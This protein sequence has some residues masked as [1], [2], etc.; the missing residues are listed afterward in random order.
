MHGQFTYPQ[1][2]YG[3]PTPRDYRHDYN[4]PV[5]KRQ[6]SAGPYD[7]PAA[8]D[9][10]SF[11]QGQQPASVYA[12]HNMSQSSSYAQVGTSNP[13]S[14]DSFAFRSHPSMPGSQIPDYSSSQLSNPYDPHNRYAQDAQYGDQAAAQRVAQSVAVNRNTSPADH[15]QY[16]EM[17]RYG[18]VTNSDQRDQKYQYPAP[19]QSTYSTTENG[20]VLPPLS[21]SGAAAQ[22][23]V[24]SASPYTYNTADGRYA[25]HAAPQSGVQGS[26]AAYPG[27]P[28]R[29]TPY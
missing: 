1:T 23:M 4:D 21:G 15:L 10:W 14:M 19:P 2:P 22:P 26:R 24:A 8:Q 11:S 20:S 16:Q 18:A 5:T 27:Y 13:P 7:R 28:A 29:N 9:P 17:N 25:A 12:P 3:Q 6:R